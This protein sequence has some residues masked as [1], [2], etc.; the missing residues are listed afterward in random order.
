MNPL[1]RR[2][3]GPAA[4]LLAVACLAASGCAMLRLR[5]VTEEQRPVTT[6]TDPSRTLTVLEPML[7]LDGPP[8][9]TYGVQLPKGKYS[10]EAEDADY[11]YFRAPAS[12]DMREIQG[13]TTVE[14]HVLAGGLMLS[15]SLFK[16]PPAGVYIEQDAS[17]KLLVFKL[18]SQFMQFEGSKWKRGG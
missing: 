14:R 8:S 16:I 17:H 18:G 1:H 4:L 5:A 2:I 10:L 3:P 12:I 11:R 6:V 15:K 7:W 13:K 9:D